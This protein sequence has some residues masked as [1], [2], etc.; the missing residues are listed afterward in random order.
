MSDDLVAAIARVLSDVTL[1]LR[2]HLSTPESLRGLIV[3]YGWNADELDAT[4]AQAVSAAMALGNVLDDL[5][6]LD[7][8]QELIAA[9][10]ELS[11]A[12]RALTG[13]TRVGLP[14]PFDQE[15]FWQE[16]P[17]QLIDD[18]L[19]SYLETGHPV[20]FSILLLIGVGEIELVTPE[21]ANRDRY[22]SRRLNWQRLTD[23]ADPEGL[24]RKV[25]RWGDPAG[26]DHDRLLRSL[27]RVLWSLQVE[28]RVVRPA[29]I[30]LDQHYPPGNQHR[31]SIRELQ[32]PLIREEAELGLTLLPVSSI[33]GV[34]SG[35]LLSPYATGALPPGADAGDGFAFELTGRFEGGTGLGVVLLPGELR[36]AGGPGMIEARVGLS[37]QPAVPWIALGTAESHRVEVPGIVAEV[38][39]KGTTAEPELLLSL[40]TPNQRPIALVIQMGEGDG[41]LNRLFGTEPQRLEF[42]GLVSWSSKTGLA[43]SGQAAVRVTIP[44]GKRIAVVELHML[45][46]GLS[47]DGQG[48]ELT[49]ALA[50]SATLGPFVASVDSVGVR[51]TLHPA[52]EGEQRVFGDLALDF[53]F[54]PPTGVGLAI[55][56]PGISGGGFLDMNRERQEYAGVLQL[57]LAGFAVSAIG[58]ITTRPGEFSLLVI[59]SVEFSPIQLG[60]GFT[61]NGVGG[62]L[63]VNRSIAVEQIQNELANGALDSMLFPRDPVRNAQR[64][65]ADLGRFFPAA[66]GQYVFGPSV[67]LGWGTPSILTI[68]LGILIEFPSPLRVVLAGRL[69]LVLPDEEAAIAV[70][71]LDILGSLDLSQ[72]RLSIDGSLRDSRIAMFALAGDIAVRASWRND[73]GF[74]LAVGGFNPRF[75]PPHGLRPL[76]RASISLADSDNPR[77]RLEAYCALTPTTVQ[78]GARLDL[79]A[80]ADIVLGTFSVAAVLGFDALVQ[81]APFSFVVDIFAGVI[82]KWNDDPFLG[83]ELAL[84]LWGPTPWRAQGTATFHFLGK[85]TVNFELTLGDS[86]PPPLPDP[87]DVLALLGSALLDPRNWEAARP[88]RE[89]PLVTVRP[90]EKGEL[91]VHPLGSLTVRQHVV[92]LNTE[93]TRFGAARPSDATRF[94][95]ARLDA[96]GARVEP[97]ALVEDL[98]ARAQFVE[99]S[100][101]ERLSA[102]AFETMPAGARFGGGTLLLPADGIHTVDE[103]VYDEYLIDLA[104]P[105]EQQP[106]TLPVSDVLGLTRRKLR[107]Y[108]GRMLPISVRPRTFRLT[109]A[110]LTPALQEAMSYGDAVRQA[111]PGQWIVAEHEVRR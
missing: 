84:T 76:R 57:D 35:L 27:A 51:L 33:D 3:R 60:Y 11:D 10:T 58:L 82:L 66:Q 72:G 85:H 13:I 40:A 88:S 30:V 74:L 70:I 2:R 36:L 14:F 79:Y 110:T 101:M 99:V 25:Y 80:S 59:I 104:V 92:P 46:I 87:V 45:T 98:F 26:F 77:L 53:G 81:L 18:L 95:V 28:A 19:I 7:E 43:L 24:I 102:P 8:P 41:L 6:S 78:F 47:T 5:Q 100:E 20:I 61:L 38:V 31:D 63:G 111:G 50:A 39:L 56:G 4:T 65:V 83:V 15:T 37:G 93:I 55:D 48:A 71:Q 91:V 73:P 16:L 62:L 32:V 106:F 1:P 21:G 64:I 42:G 90:G 86:G 17:L 68:T 108:S 54:L 22:L 44:I 34:P 107:P 103:L 96:A 29:T 49:L 75:R 69:R 12:V 94:T 89:T 105:T 67:V 9:F 52:G 109:D 97:L 23:L